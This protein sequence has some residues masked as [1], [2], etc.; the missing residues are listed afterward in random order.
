MNPVAI[1]LLIIRRLLSVLIDFP[2]PFLTKR[3]AAFWLALSISFADIF[4]ADIP[5]K[6]K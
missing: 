3:S 2:P 1:Q 4:S 6:T 5:V